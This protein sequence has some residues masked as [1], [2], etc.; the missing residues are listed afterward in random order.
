VKKPISVLLV[1]DNPPFVRVA[2][3]F[4]A[5]RAD[6][7]RLVGTAKDAEEALAQTQALEPQVVLLDLGLP[8]ISGLDVIPRLR[9]LA[10]EVGI[11]VLTLSEPETHEQACLE[12]G[13]HEFVYKPT[14]VTQLIPAVQRA[15]EAGAR[16][17]RQQR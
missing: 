5:R 14:L 8:G 7:V 11:V 13:A 17:G 4:L 1:D 6:D 2:T 9:E 15:A 12:A 3:R 16:G 10:P